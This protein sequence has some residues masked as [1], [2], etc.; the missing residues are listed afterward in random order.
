MR[1]RTPHADATT[2]CARRSSR[3]SRLS[4]RPAAITA[5]IVAGVSLSSG[6]YRGRSWCVAGARA[7]ACGLASALWSLVCRVQEWSYLA[8]RH[9]VLSVCRVCRRFRCSASIASACFAFLAHKSPAPG[10]RAP[11]LGNRFLRRIHLNIS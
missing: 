11:Y 10:R 8:Y 3:S 4:N 2:A 9:R 1:A 5:M 6:R 7:C